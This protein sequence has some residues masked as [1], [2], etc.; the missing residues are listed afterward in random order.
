M[1]V[2]QLIDALSEFPQEMPVATFGDV[3]WT[4]KDDPRWIEVKIK[5]WVHGNWPY[6]KPDFEF[7]DLT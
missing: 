5:T 1:T 4:T 7:V 3:D 6:D 2:K